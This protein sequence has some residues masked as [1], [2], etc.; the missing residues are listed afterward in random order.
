MHLH[1]ENTDFAYSTLVSAI[2]NLTALKCPINLNPSP[3]LIIHGHAYWC[4]MI[5]LPSPK[6]WLQSGTSQDTSSSINGDPIFRLSSCFF[7]DFFFF[8]FLIPLSIFCSCCFWQWS[9]PAWSEWDS[10]TGGRT[11]TAQCRDKFEC[12]DENVQSQVEDK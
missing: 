7:V 11:K 2:S 1:T 3:S 12:W 9:N 6:C 5:I 10:E 8:F 4:Q